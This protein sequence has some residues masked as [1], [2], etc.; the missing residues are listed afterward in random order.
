MEL[1]R[2][3]VPDVDV[4]AATSEL[5]GLWTELGSENSDSFDDSG[6]RAEALASTSIGNSRTTL[7]LLSGAVGFVLL[8]ACVNV[9]NLT[10]ART[11]S[12]TREIAVRAALGASRYRVVRQFVTESLMVAIAGG[13]VGVLAAIFG[14]DAIL[15]TFGSSVPR[16][17]EIELNRWVLGFA[18][19][20]SLLT[21]LVVGFIPAMLAKPDSS[22]LK[23]GG[24]GA[25]PRVTHLRKTLVIAEVALSLVLA[26][27]AGLLLRSFWQAQ[28]TDPG[29][30]QNNVLVADLWLPPSRYSEETSVIQYHEQLVQRIQ[31]L[32]GV[33]SM[34]MI[35]MVPM[36]RFGSNVTR[37]QAQDNDDLEASFVEVRSTSP[38]YFHT[39]QIPL[40]QGRSFSEADYDAEGTTEAVTIINQELARIL[41]PDRDPIGRRLDRGSD[42][43]EI[44]GIIG[45]VKSFGADREARPSFYRPTGVAS[46]LV[47]RTIGDPENFAPQLRDIVAAVD[48][49]VSVVRTSTL[50]NIFEGR[51]GNRRFQLTLL[52]LFA[53]V[54]VAL[55]AI[56][57]Y[58][59]MSYTVEQRTREMGVRLALGQSPDSLLR[60]IVAQGV[61]LTGYGLLIGGAGSLL[62]KNVIESFLYEVEA[63]DPLTYLS[64]IL[65]L[66]IVAVGSC[67]IPARRASRVDPMEAMR[68]E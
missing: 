7:Y 1:A 24:R 48:P 44:V 64:T 67:Y 27:G 25:A 49:A 12:R 41:F 56:G 20:I 62:L 61:R 13:V 58:G 34:G 42:G 57:I 40:I 45:D 59:V 50:Q 29:F 8:I 11:E 60:L 31:A 4:L 3:F 47:I 30:N 21:G 16:S 14:V 52:L 68:Y 63:G 51:L 37:L 54:A 43:L 18:L 15:A 26:T 33:E 66:G 38:G 28:G 17:D 32:P 35:N 2:C 5:H 23:E 19:G 9:G 53:A 65:L 6:M 46:N 10:L 36:R 22:A 55:G 39:L